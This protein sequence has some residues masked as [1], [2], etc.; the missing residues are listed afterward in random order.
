MIALIYLVRKHDCGASLKAQGSEE[1]KLHDMCD[2][3]QATHFQSK[4]FFTR[5]KKRE[6]T[7]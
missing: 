2:I 7:S 3:F 4:Y 5:Q 1:T 6:D